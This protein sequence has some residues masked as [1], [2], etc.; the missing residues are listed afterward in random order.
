MSKKKAIK[1]ATA[2]A[3]ALTGAVAVAQPQAD[4]ATNSVDQAITKATKQVDKAFN[5]YYNTAKKSNKLPSGSA[6]RKEV[7]LAE[8]YYIAAEA[9]IAKKGGSKAK[10]AAYTKKLEKSKTSLNRAKNYVAAVSVT[11][12]S[13]RTALDKAIESGKQS[14]VQSAQAALNKKIAEFEKAVSK[15]FGPDAR[16]LLTK[17]YTTPA[18]AESAAVDAEMKVYAAY[19][20]I[21]RGNLIEKDIEKAGQLIDSVRAEVEELKA[22]DTK[23]AGNLVK[24]AEKNNK[25]Y[26]AKVEA[27]KVPVVASVSAINAKEIKVTFNKEVD[28]TTAENAANY[29]LKLKGTAVA[30]L[31]ADLQEDGKTVLLNKTDGTDIFTNGDYYTVE[32]E[33][34]LT[35]DLSKKVA[36]YKTATLN[37]FDNAAPTVVSSELNGSNVRVYF[38][39]PV[40]GVQLKV[41]GSA[42]SAVPAST[43]KDGKYY[44]E[45]PASADE[46]KAGTHSVTVYGATDG[47]NNTLSVAA[48]QYVVSDDTSAPSI[49]SVTADK[50]NTFKV[51]VSEKLAVEP[52][53]EVKKGGILFIDSSN[54]AAQVALD[55]EDSSDLTYIV[56]VPANATSGS[57]SLYGKDENSVALSVKITNIKDNSNLTGAEYNGSVTLTK[58]AVGPKVLSENTN[59]V[60][61]TGLISV[62]FD[63]NITLADSTKVKVYKDGVLLATTATAAGE[64]LNIQLPEVGKAATYSVKLEEGAVKDAAGNKNAALTTT[65]TYASKN[66]ITP[67]ITLDGTNKYKV[68]FATP[69]SDMTDSATTVSNYTLDG[70]ALPAGTTIDFS[71]DKK[72]V[73]ITLPKESVAKTS[74]GSLQI[75]TN[76]VNKAGQKVADAKGE[77]FT[78]LVALTDNVKPVLQSGKFI[79]SDD[80]KLANQVELTFSENVT[81]GNVDDYEFIVNGAK[82]TATAITF[83]NDKATVTFGSELNVAQALSVKVLPADD[84]DD[85]DMDTKDTTGNKLTEGT[86]VTVNTVK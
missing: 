80:N 52:S 72:T 53:F 3:I 31:T 26:E 21:E 84:Q 1:I 23:L 4:A 61:A 30:G 66:D 71:G 37:Y 12:K 83:T 39:E 7:K 24:A 43:N 25:A 29:E 78:Q 44:V 5:L 10:K 6:I 65:A 38:N 63:E 81:A 67:T 41:D 47:D 57:Y 20:Q 69:N 9:E 50:S 36:T 16:R 14:T 2:S 55:P 27:L 86:T 13:S 11:L 75:S 46:K 70:K 49:T 68:A 85:K 74:S 60:S 79:D 76:V 82:V 77:A 34:V 40:S 48:T 73:I 42:L 17:T 62:K 33:E 59:T 18:K 35:K 58:D 28:K 19:K 22:K 51:K 15:V 56:T 32:V 54:T 64:F 8:A 45:R